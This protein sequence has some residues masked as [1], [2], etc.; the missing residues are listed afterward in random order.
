MA[1]PVLRCLSC[2]VWIAALRNRVI[3]G[4]C[5]SWAGPGHA[6]KPITCWMR[7]EQMP[8]K[9]GDRW[10][11]HFKSIQTGPDG[12]FIHHYNR[13]F[14]KEKAGRLPAIAPMES[15]SISQQGIMKNSC[16]RL[17]SFRTYSQAIWEGFACCC[18][19]SEELPLSKGRNPERIPTLS[20]TGWDQRSGNTEGDKQTITAQH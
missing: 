5:T 11:I 7:C 15:S 19:L 12:V 9:R 17:W 16:Y 3:S 20:F 2:F 10:M 6:L 18:G 13:C 14:T 8:G 1:P 4:R